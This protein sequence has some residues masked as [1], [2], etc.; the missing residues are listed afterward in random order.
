MTDA[1]QLLIQTQQTIA[2]LEAWMNAIGANAG[3]YYLNNGVPYISVEAALAAIPLADRVQ[4][5]TINVGGEEY[6]LQPDMETFLPKHESLTIANN[7]LA[8]AKLLY[9][10]SGYVLYRRTAGVGP[11]EA[12][13]L[14]TL[15]TDLGVISGSDFVDALNGKVTA[16]EGYSLVTDAQLLAIADIANKVDKVDGESLIADT[17]ITRLAGVVQN[18]YTLKFPAS[19]SVAGRIG[20]VL[21]APD[22]WTLAPGGSAVD[23]LVTHGLS[24]EIAGVTVWK[25]DSDGKR[26]L[27]GNAAYSGLLAPDNNSVLIES[28]ATI[29]LPIHI[30]FTFGN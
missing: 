8:L 14:A 2:D 21:S 26:L 19:E 29:A 15:A 30:E 11:W 27:Y 6:Q 3:I 25:I 23:L 24:R 20:G 5:M 16:V 4:Y 17:E 22:G 7:S 9:T 18:V 10:S 28:L 13:T 12:Q 1:E